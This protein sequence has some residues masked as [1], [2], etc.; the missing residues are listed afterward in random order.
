[1]L[2]FFPAVRNTVRRAGRRVA[3]SSDFSR[4]RSNDDNSMAHPPHAMVAPSTAATAAVIGASDTAAREH[5]DG[6][7]RKT[8]IPHGGGW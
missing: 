4:C 8:R 3:L 1:M 2:E 7:A 5:G 6:L